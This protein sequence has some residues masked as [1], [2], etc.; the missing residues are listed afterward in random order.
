MDTFSSPSSSCS[1]GRPAALPG[2]AAA[3][4]LVVVVVVGVDPLPDR[5]GALSDRPNAGAAV[6]GAESDMDT[7][8]AAAGTEASCRDRLTGSES[9]VLFAETAGSMDKT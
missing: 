9:K 1:C 6:A 2:T 3:L 5:L 8:A 4:L 7:V